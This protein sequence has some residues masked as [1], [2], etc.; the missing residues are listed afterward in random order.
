MVSEDAHFWAGVA[1]GL[2]VALGDFE[3]S[4]LSPTTEEYVDVNYHAKDAKVKAEPTSDSD[5]EEVEAEA[6]ED[7]EV[8]PKRPRGRPRKNAENTNSL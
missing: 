8:K 7:V 6:T 2:R 4:E 5:E 3:L 1:A